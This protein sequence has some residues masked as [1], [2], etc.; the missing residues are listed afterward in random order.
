MLRLGNHNSF[1]ESRKLGFNALLKDIILNDNL[2]ITCFSLFIYQYH[3]NSSIL[4][5]T[6][7]KVIALIP[8]CFISLLVFHSLSLFQLS[9]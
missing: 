1:N 6:S 9:Q 2:K 5:I 4:S 8:L 3:R 7:C